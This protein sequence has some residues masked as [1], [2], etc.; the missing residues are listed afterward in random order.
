[1]IK[2]IIAGVC[3]I[4]SAAGFSQENNASPY[5]YYGIGDV[6][7]KGTAENRS[8]GGLGIMPDSI[9]VNLQ[10][11]ATYNALKYTVY[12]IGVSDKSRTLKTETQSESANRLTLDY[13]AVAMPFNKIGIAFGLM[14]YTSVG[15]RIQDTTTVAG[16]DYLRRS[17]GKGGINRAFFGGSYRITPKFSVGA[18][19]Q[20]NFGTIETK[21]ISPVFSNDVQYSTREINRSYYSGASFNIGA[22]YMTRVKNKYDWTSSITYAPKSKLSSD[23]DRMLSSIILTQAGN[24]VTV[25]QLPTVSIKDKVDL[26]SVFTIGT[27]IG[28]A[29]KWFAGIEYSTQSSNSLGARFDQVTNVSFESSQRLSLG[30]YFIPKYNSFTSYLSRVTYRTGLKYEKTGLVINNEDINDVAF[31]FGMGLPLGG[32]I[33]GSNLNVGAEI[34]RRGTTKAN[35]IQENYVNIM[36]SLSI[37]DRWFAK[38][39]YD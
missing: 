16:S 37:N 30:G 34:G 36:L 11:P 28:R 17:S 21:S 5:S 14:P 7:F 38:R 35:L 4:F 22:T 33:G 13:L 20:Y 10:N 18:D 8:M 26:P 19:F 12:T 2:K 24:E 32:N 6:K 1:M 3:L 25:D 31:T 29:R 15:Y 27:G 23:T 9:H 39:R